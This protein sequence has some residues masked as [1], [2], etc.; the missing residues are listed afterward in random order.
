MVGANLKL[1]ESTDLRHLEACR[2]GST[3]S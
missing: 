2:Y 3:Q 1:A